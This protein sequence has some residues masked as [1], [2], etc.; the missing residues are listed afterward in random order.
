MIG[1]LYG[2]GMHRFILDET[3][4]GFRV[5]AWLAQERAEPLAALLDVQY[6]EYLKEAQ[7]E[8]E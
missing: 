3:E 6:A 1:G 4:L 5:A 8:P 7:V 2:P